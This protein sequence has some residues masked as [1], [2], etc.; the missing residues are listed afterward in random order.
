MKLLRIGRHLINPEKICYVALWGYKTADVYFMGQKKP[1]EL[2]KEKVLALLK[3]VPSG[4]EPA[5]Q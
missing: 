1:L 2:D 5:D 4:E 3:E